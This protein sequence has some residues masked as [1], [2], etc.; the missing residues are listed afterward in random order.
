[1]LYKLNGGLGG[2]I[3]GLTL[4]TLFLAWSILYCRHLGKKY[5]LECS[6]CG[7]K[8][9]KKYLYVVNHGFFRSYCSHCHK[10]EYFSVIEDK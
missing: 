10:E 1:M 7:H 2:L 5:I 9:K 6:T 4:L 8:V 3:I